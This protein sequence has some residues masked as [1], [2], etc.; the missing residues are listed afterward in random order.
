[1]EIMRYKLYI[2]G[3]LCEAAGEGTFKSCSPF[4]GEPLA[5]C[6]LAG[7]EDCRRAIGAAQKAFEE[8]NWS[9]KTVEGRA[10]YLRNLLYALQRNID[11]IAEIE[12]RDVGILRAHALQIAKEALKNFESYL[13]LGKQVQTM[14]K[15]GSNYPGE[16]TIS[17]VRREPFGVCGIILPWNLPFDIL[18]NKLMPALLTG[19]CAVVKPSPLAPCSTL[20]L[21]TLLKDIGFPAGVVNIITGDGETGGELAKNPSV[22]M[23]SFTGSTDTGKAIYR[24]GAK[25]FKKLVLECGGNS[26]HLVFD[27]IDIKQIVLPIMVSI[28]SHAGQVCVAGRRLLVQ[29]PLYDLMLRNL[30]ARARFIEYVLH[31]DCQPKLFPVEPVINEE[32][33]RKIDEQVGRAVSQGARLLCGG[34]R[35]EKVES[36]CFY[37][38]TVLA[39]V[40][41]AMDIFHEEVFG[42][43]LLV[44]RFKDEGEAVEL[45]NKSGYGLAA[46]VWTADVEQAG[47]LGEE[48]R[49][50]SVYLGTTPFEAHNDY[51]PFGGYKESGTGRE[52]GIAGLMEFLQVKHLLR[53]IQ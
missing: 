2:D 22:G 12:A 5:V 34:K 23:L 30:S 21:G 16:G 14:E 52:H 25:Y 28:F 17:M 36:G 27:G 43:V 8:G 11:R 10:E 24:E 3:E 46:M 1:M 13:E 45:A 42:P 19:N 49:A 4:S 31:I 20:Y 38:P 50:G 47:R 9:R 26:A 32:Q 53:K 7:A 18:I 48:I 15:I 44:A 51:A 35:A 39:D 41:S 37:E 29:E 33:L 6:S 40:T